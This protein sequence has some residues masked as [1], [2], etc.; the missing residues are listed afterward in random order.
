MNKKFKKDKNKKAFNQYDPSRHPEPKVQEKSELA[1][2]PVPTHFPG[3]LE[4]LEASTK[5]TFAEDVQI[6]LEAEKKQLLGETNGTP[7]EFSEDIEIALEAERHQLSGRTPDD[8]VP[9]ETPDDEVL[10]VEEP[11]IEELPLEHP[12][13][14]VPVEEPEKEVPVEVP[15]EEQ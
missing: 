2:R 4:E 8:V 14:E 6:A 5:K 7:G 11:E 9:V 13:E 1:G 12:V 15:G 10:P 3:E